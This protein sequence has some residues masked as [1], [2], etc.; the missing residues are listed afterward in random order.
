MSIFDDAVEASGMDEESEFE[1]LNDALGFDDSW[2]NVPDDQGGRESDEDNS[3]PGEQ[4]GNE[5]SKE[6][7]SRSRNLDGTFADEIF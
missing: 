4:E 6:A 1:D 7:E 3:I 5:L 2:S